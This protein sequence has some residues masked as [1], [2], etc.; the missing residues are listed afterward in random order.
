MTGSALHLSA[1]PLKFPN[2]SED[3]S[4]PMTLKAEIR[5]AH[6]CNS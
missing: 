5:H 6:I 2:P 4:T 3:V 1:S